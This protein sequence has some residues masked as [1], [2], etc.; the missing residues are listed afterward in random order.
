MF[1]NFLFFLK[2]VIDSFF[3]EININK[4]NNFTNSVWIEKCCIN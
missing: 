3:C 1:A 2:N 4:D